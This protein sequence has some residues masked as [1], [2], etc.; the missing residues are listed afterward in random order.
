M[1][2]STRHLRRVA[3]V[4]TSVATAAIALAAC[5][6]PAEPPWIGVEWVR[7]AG[8]TID[9][10]TGGYTPDLQRWVTKGG[11]TTGPLPGPPTLEILDMFGAL[12]PI[13]PDG[14]AKFPWNGFAG[15]GITVTPSTPGPYTEYVLHHPGG[16]CAVAWADADSRVQSV[17]PS[18]DGKLAAVVS[19]VSFGGGG[20]SQ[21][22]IVSL[23]AVDCPTVVSAQYSFLGGFEPP[24]GYLV[25]SRV[26]WSPNSAAVAFPLTAAG[27]PPAG[28]GTSIM[29]L[30]ASAGATPTP[31]LAPSEGCVSPSG[32]SVENRLMLT[33]LGPAPYQSRIITIPM[34]GGGTTN[35]I[36]SF[37]GTA[38]TIGPF[39]H[40]GYYV[41]GTNTIVFDKNLPVV[42]ADGL[43]QAWSQVHT[44]Y[45]VPFAQSTPITGSAPPLEWYPALKSDVLPDYEYTDVPRWE[46]VM[47]L[48]R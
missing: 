27:N 46:F 32:W 16:S 19:S 15:E 9:P 8:G 29:R 24:S 38:D 35:T 18:P 33:C 5:V 12:G 39:F 21:L 25:G 22:E 30:S 4:L 2:R 48:A 14:T 7:D 42:N 45:D 10:L 6:P 31:V 47:R 40:F 34:G 43:L 37:T 44:A 26:V 23:G 28:T 3:A 36:D 17:T 41:P 1:R 11:T 13:L 20:Q